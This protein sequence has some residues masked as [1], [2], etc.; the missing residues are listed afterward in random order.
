MEFFISKIR[1]TGNLENSRYL[2]APKIYPTHDNN[3]SPKKCDF[4]NYK[5]ES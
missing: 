1:E 4:P 3:P 2:N 5:N